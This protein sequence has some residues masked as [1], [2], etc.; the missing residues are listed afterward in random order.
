MVR[1]TPSFNHGCVLNCKV[2]GGAK[3]LQTLLKLDSK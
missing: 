2:G 1:I 3:K